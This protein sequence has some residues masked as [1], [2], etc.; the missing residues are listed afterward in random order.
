MKLHIINDGDIFKV[1]SV[2][3][4]D[5]S[6]SKTYNLDKFYLKSQ[7]KMIWDDTTVIRKALLKIREDNL[8]RY[9]QLFQFLNKSYVV[10]IYHE[11]EIKYTF[12]G[13]SLF[14]K[15]EHYNFNPES[16]DHIK[17]RMNKVNVCGNILN[18]YD[19]TEIINKDWVKPFGGDWVSW[20]KDNQGE[21]IED[22]IGRNSV[23]KNIDALKSEGF[24][25]YLAKVVS[26]ERDRK[27]SKLFA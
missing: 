11:N 20:L 24:G 4:K 13:K 10:C 16:N 5:S 2:L 8:Q 9:K 14:D 23:S 17:V 15:L 25:D 19:D 27:I 21:Y 22:I 7:S 3:F 18:R 1:L 12:F 6:A 26:D